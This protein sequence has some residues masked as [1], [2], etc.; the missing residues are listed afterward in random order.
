MHKS[1]QLIG[2]YLHHILKTP[3]FTSF[4]VG[5]LGKGD[6]KTTTTT[7]IPCGNTFH[8]YTI[9]NILTKF[10]Y[11]INAYSWCYIVF[12]FFVFLFRPDKGRRGGV[13]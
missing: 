4:V 2:L 13:I 11:I 3:F 1:T 10:N 7:T 9:I 6:S 5:Q 8:S 12:P